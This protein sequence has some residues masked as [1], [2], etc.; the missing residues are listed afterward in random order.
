MNTSH[1]ASFAERG[2]ALGLRL[3]E[4]CY[5]L[6]GERAARILLV[7]VA[8]YFLLAA[9]EARRSSFDYFR[10][11]QRFGGGAPGLPRPGWRTSFR[12]MLAF[13]ESALHKLGAWMQR[14]DPASIDFPQRSA[15]D[16]LVRSGRG[17]LLLSAHVGNIEMLRALAVTRGLTTVNAV[18]YTRHAVRFKRVL[19]RANTSFGVNLLEVSDL[20]PETGMML[21]EKIDRGEILVIVG[22][23][24][25]AAEHGRTCRAGFLGAP[26]RFPQGPYILAATL[27]CPVYT[28]FCVK[29]GSRYRVH[30]ELFADRIVLPRRQR[31]AALEEYARAYARSM[32]AMCMLYPYQWFNF[33]DFW[34]D[35]GLVS[36][37]GNRA[38]TA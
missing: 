26:A 10:R 15:L 33:Y 31:D 36:D 3:T 12:H 11:L 1:W 29:A 22:D 35:A 27:Q 8:A 6:L 23:R 4:A 17:A 38:A 37:P 25:P 32:E 5:R 19:E 18:V 20:G 9:S 34:Q 2:S 30:F 13:A 14:I 28:F 16:D 24:V 7:P 21:S